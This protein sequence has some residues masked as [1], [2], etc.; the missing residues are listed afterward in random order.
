MSAKVD[1][2]R[3]RSF[4]RVVSSMSIMVYWPSFVVS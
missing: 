1:R 3:A 4:T 2:R